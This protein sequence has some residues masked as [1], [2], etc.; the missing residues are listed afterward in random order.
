[1]FGSDE[2]DFL[3]ALTDTE[4]SD[5]MSLLL[6]WYTFD[7][8]AYVF[9]SFWHATFIILAGFATAQYT[10]YKVNSWTTSASSYDWDYNKALRSLMFSVLC[11][12]VNYVS[13]QIVGSQ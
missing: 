9:S 12:T 8:A 6:S 13:G 4:S 3:E 7:L 5:T 2:N 1:M 11:G 10:L